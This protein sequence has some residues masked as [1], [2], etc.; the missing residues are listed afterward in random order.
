ISR[1]SCN[2]SSL[3][4]IRERMSRFAYSSLTHFIF[5]PRT[6]SPW[7]AGPG[8]HY[9]IVSM[10]KSGTRVDVLS[11]D[12]KNGYSK[13][14][15]DSGETGWVMTRYLMGQPAAREQLTKHWRP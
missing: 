14:R 5:L 10:L 6:H 15:L 9:G 8:S 12:K 1:T 3:Y 4:V 13:I 2:A 11:Q 7:R